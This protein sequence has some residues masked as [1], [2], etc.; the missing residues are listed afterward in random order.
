MSG[1]EMLMAGFLFG[2]GFMIAYTLLNITT[3]LIS[4]WIVKGMVKKYTKSKKPKDLNF[5]GSKDGKI[6]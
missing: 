5:G 2:L 1:L 6:I 4:A 3:Q